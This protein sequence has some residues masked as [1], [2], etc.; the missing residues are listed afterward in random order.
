MPLR[1][2]VI[3]PIMVYFN[4]VER[5]SC[6]VVQYGFEAST[7]TLYVSLIFLWLDLK[8]EVVLTASKAHQISNGND[9]T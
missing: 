2:L 4:P 8:F 3:E 7:E 5:S 6:G 1:E 9:V